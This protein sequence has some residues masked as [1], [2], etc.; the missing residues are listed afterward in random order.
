ME[1]AQ[2]NAKRTEENVQP[3]QQTT[4]AP[5]ERPPT[6]SDTEV[7][8]WLEDYR[9]AWQQKDIEKL[10]QLGEVRPQDADAVQKIL[11]GYI[12]FSVTFENSNIDRKGTQA[13]ISFN[14][15]DHINGKAMPQPGRQVLVVEKRTD[16]TID[17]IN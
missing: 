3:V 4:N 8:E 1:E 7:R 16:G 12:S 14:R 9:Q 11:S 6:L 13:T 17:R 10:V 2:R 15:V 5:V